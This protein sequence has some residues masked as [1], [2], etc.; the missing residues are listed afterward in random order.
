MVETHERMHSNQL[1]WIDSR[2]W[3]LRHLRLCG[4]A[5][6]GCAGPISATPT[7]KAVRSGR[8]TATSGAPCTFP[9]GQL[10]VWGLS[11]IHI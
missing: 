3:I 7:A 4:H 11:L 9:G 10:G 1:P 5:S 2:R 8:A 6:C